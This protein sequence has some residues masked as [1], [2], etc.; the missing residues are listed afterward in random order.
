MEDKPRPHQGPRLESQHNVIM[1]V[2]LPQL[3]AKLTE[4][5]CG[6]FDLCVPA[7]M[8]KFSYRIA[9]LTRQNTIECSHHDENYA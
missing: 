2:D 8:I 3:E 5:A 9:S 1:C 6:L 4:G 7:S